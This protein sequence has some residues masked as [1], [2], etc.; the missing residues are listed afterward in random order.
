MTNPHQTKNDMKGGS[1]PQLT[2][3]QRPQ[4]GSESG[5][6]CGINGAVTL[7]TLFANDNKWGP[8]RGVPPVFLWREIYHLQDGLLKRSGAAFVCATL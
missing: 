3:G 8:N 4:K 6:S 1:P 2:F 5:I 7:E